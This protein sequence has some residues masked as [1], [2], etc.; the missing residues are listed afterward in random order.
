MRLLRLLRQEDG[1]A[2][3]MALGIL[4][5]LSLTTTTAL[6]YSGTNARSSSR[7]QKGAKAFSVAEASLSNAL[8]A[9]FNPTNNALNPYLFCDSAGQSLPCER[10][11]TYEDGT[12]R[13]TGTL[14]ETT[15]IWTLTAKGTTANPTNPGAA[16]LS[17]TLTAKVSVYASES[18]TLTNPSW[19]YIYSR[20]TGNTCDTTFGNSVEVR[21]P[22][23]VAGNLCLNNQAWISG[24]PLQVHGSVTMAGNNQQIGTASTPVNEVHVKNGCKWKDNP[25][26]NPCQA[27]TGS[28]GHDN[29]WATILD[30][31]PETIAAPAVD[32]N[33]WYLNANPGPY[34][35]CNTQSGT[36]PSFDN[37]QGPRNSPDLSKRNNSLP[38]VVD[39]APAGA[40]YTCATDGGQI[41]WN[42][43][44]KMLTANGTIFIDGSA[45]IETGTT[46]SYTGMSTI[47]IS[48]TLLIKNT[49]V[50]AVLSGSNCTLTG[51]DPGQKVVVFVAN[52]NGSGG[53]TQGQV[54]G[55]DSINVKS[56][57]FQGGLYATNAI[58][59]DTTSQAD[60]PIDGSPVILGQSTGGAFPSFVFVPAGTPGQITP[61]YASPQPPQFFSG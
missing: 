5:V 7:D 4:F 31:N 56:S 3:V 1:I 28:S 50:C 24:G 49:K 18:Q 23:Y 42:A 12:A 15:G 9:I 59:I 19:N 22:L 13:W 55:G 17:R 11:T 61:K 47:Y 25:L 57:Q 26:H 54:P 10:T 21:S 39:L 60:G 53:G 52:G 6:Y 45:K 2:L 41:S 36:P 34:Y 43:S 48:G 14:N 20:S 51:W 46:I 35:P 38:S 44:T 29:L 33:A 8:S 16:A 30:N 40:S 32:W 58:D 27:G 37:D